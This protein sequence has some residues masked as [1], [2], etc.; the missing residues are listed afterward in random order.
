MQEAH[1]PARSFATH[2]SPSPPSGSADAMLANFVRRP[3]GSGHARFAAVQC[4][5]VEAG[6]TDEGQDR[7]RAILTSS[8][9]VS[10]YSQ[11]LRCDWSPGEWV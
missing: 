11:M 5:D 4:L 9:A 1:G 10:V 6:A 2:G 7:R 3:H 8:L